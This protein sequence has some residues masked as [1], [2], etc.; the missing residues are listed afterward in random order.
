M[1]KHLITNIIKT[2]EVPYNLVKAGT[3]KAFLIIFGRC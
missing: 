2:S 1:P 3:G